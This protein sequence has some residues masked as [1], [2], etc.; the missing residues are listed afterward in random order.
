MQFIALGSDPSS[1]DISTTLDRRRPYD[2]QDAKMKL[3]FS[4][5]DT[6]AIMPQCDT[7]ASAC[8]LT[9]YGRAHQEN[10]GNSIGMYFSL[11]VTLCFQCISYCIGQLA[12]LFFF[13]VEN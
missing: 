10:A 2:S 1:E 4:L 6:I 11:S 9:S 5:C 7:S 12:F 13:T 3:L 8:V